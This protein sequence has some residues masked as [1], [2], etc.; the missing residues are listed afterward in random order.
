MT[1]RADIFSKQAGGE[2]RL[3]YTCNLGWLDL[4][5]MNPSGPAELWR[6]MLAGGDDAYI[7]DAVKINPSAALALA[8]PRAVLSKLNVPSELIEKNRKFIT[9]RDG[10][11]GFKLEY[12]QSMHKKFGPRRFSRSAGGAY[13]IRQ[14]LTLEQKN[15]SPWLFTWRSAMVSKECRVASLKVY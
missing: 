15:Q 9:F 10:A 4:G 13:L 1:T 6:N 7:I 11:R 8:A 5:H 14:G 12:K 3:A 2:S